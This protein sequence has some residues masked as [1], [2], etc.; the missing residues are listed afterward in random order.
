MNIT[1]TNVLKTTLETNLVFRV[2]CTLSDG[3]RFTLTGRG[4]DTPD[5]LSVH[6]A[7]MFLSWQLFVDITGQPPSAENMTAENLQKYIATVVA[8]RMTGE[9]TP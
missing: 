6:K 3:S 2:V 1:H 4:V 8:Q 7:D 5:S 9:S